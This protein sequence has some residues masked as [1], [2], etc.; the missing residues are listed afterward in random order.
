MVSAGVQPAETLAPLGAAR[1]PFTELVFTAGLD[2]DVKV[3]GV[4][5]ERQSL[6]ADAALSGIVLLD[7][8]GL[9]IGLSKTLNSDHRALMSEAFTVKAG[10]SK[11]ITVAGNRPTTETTS[12]AGQVIKLAVVAVDAGTASVTGLPITGTGQT[13]NTSL[14]IGTATLTRGPMDP[15]ASN[16]KEVGTTGYT[17]S[18]IRVTAGSAED[19]WVKSI[20]WNQSGSVATSDLANMKTVVDGTSY[21][22]VVSSDGKYYTSN[23]GP[24]G[25]LIG[26]GNNKEVYIKGDVTGGSGRTA[27]FDLY[28]YT[29]LYLVG[30]TYSYGVTPTATQVAAS[31]DDGNFHAAN[32]NYDAFQVTVNAGSLTVSKATTPAAQ[33]VAINLSSQ[34]LGGFEVEVKGEPVSVSQSVFWSQLTDSDAGAEASGDDITAL[35]LIDSTGKVVAGPKDGANVTTLGG[36]V[37]FTDSITFP[38][39]KSIYTLK[40][41]L[42]TNF[43]NNDTVVASTTPSADWTTVTGQTTGTTITPSASIITANTMTAK[44]ATV[45]ISTNA[46]NPTAQSIVAGVQDFVFAKITFDASNSGEDV[47]FS[48]LQFDVNTPTNADY[49]TNCQLW[50]GAT[51][52]NTGGNTVTPTTDGDKTFTLD[53]HLIITKSSIKVINF[54]CDLPGGL[55]SG[56]TIRIDTP[57][58]AG[59]ITGTG[60]T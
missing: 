49:P 46:N 60:V 48:T 1:V 17:F 22:V 44:A 55:T 2:G 15:G 43:E 13:M 45:A 54:A 38:V 4:T 8:A 32:P 10:T 31:A 3:N 29:D 7:E 27:D 42:S 11:K 36:K 34:V 47:R 56:S 51:A 35:S 14:T 21:D 28:R 6:G 50:D 20:S 16:S 52:L 39:G 18:S 41:K 5:I 57:D 58:A 19:I 25:I 30:S 24:A 37:T 53:Q 33:N 12:T 9:Q 40:G 59:D 26:K 23:F